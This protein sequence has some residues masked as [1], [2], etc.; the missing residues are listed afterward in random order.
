MGAEM[1]ERVNALYARGIGLHLEPRQTVLASAREIAGA[2]RR[3]AL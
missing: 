3:G 2:K 1:W